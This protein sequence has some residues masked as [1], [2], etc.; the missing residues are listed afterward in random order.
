MKVLVALSLFLWSG[1]MGRERNLID[2]LLLA[3]PRN[4]RLFRNTVGLFETKDGRKIQTGLCTGSSDLIGWTVREISQADVGK[5]VAV[6]TAIEVKSE[7]V[8][9]TDE[10]KR[11]L[12][13]VEASGGIAELKREKNGELIAEDYGTD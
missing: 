8:K 11:F 4:V 5:R 2:R 7:R 1:L 6:F 3:L 12:A 10:Q 9:T 13:A